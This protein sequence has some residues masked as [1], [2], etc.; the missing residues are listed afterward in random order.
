MFNDYSEN[1]AGIQSKRNYQET[2]ESDRIPPQKPPVSVATINEKDML[3]LAVK[4]LSV[5]NKVKWI[6]SHLL[7]DLDSV[8]EAADL[9]DSLYYGVEMDIET[10]INSLV[11]FRD[12]FDRERC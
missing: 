12:Y 2:K 3:E 1:Q 9:V 11:Q 10:V 6:W 4:S 7:P 5:A 8:K